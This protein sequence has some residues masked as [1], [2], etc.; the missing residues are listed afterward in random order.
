MASRYDAV[1]G[2]KYPSLKGRQLKQMLARAGYSAERTRGS[3][4]RMVAAGRPSFTLAYHD[5]ADV[6]PSAVKAV[7]ERQAKLSPDEIKALLAG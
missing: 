6:S 3:H 4:M 7:L 2:R 5:K 1:M